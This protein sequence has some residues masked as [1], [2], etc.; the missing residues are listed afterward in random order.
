MLPD[1]SYLNF[2]LVRECSSNPQKPPIYKTY[3]R[4]NFKPMQNRPEIECMS[5]GLGH[6]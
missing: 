3:D 2:V 6:L 4:D 1:Y 5:L